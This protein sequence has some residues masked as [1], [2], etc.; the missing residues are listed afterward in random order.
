MERTKV[1]AIIPARQEGEWIAKTVHSL[2]DS[3]AELE[4]IIVV[5]DGSTDGSCAELTDIS[6]LVRVIRHDKPRGIA[7]SRNEGVAFCSAEID[8][9][10]ILD[11]HMVIPDAAV[12]MVVESAL[13]HNAVVCSSV[14]GLG[15]TNVRNAARFLFMDNKYVGYRY[16]FDG[17]EELRS[18]RLMA[19]GHEPGRVKDGESRWCYICGEQMAD[20]GQCASCSGGTY[21][22]TRVCSTEPE[23]VYLVEHITGAF[24]AIPREVWNKIGGW[25]NTAGEWGHSEP[26]ISIACFFL[27]IPMVCDTGAI[28]GH[29]YGSIGYSFDALSQWRN[30]ARAYAVMFD[31]ETI[32]NYWYPILST[33]LSPET[34]KEIGE[35]AIAQ[36]EVFQGNKVRTDREF[37]T[38]MLKAPVTEDCRIPRVAVV[39]PSC[40][41]GEEVTRTVTSL[42]DAQQIWTPH[43]VVVDDHSTDESCE[44]GRRKL[45]EVTARRPGCLIVKPPHRLGVAGARNFG[46][47][48]DP[49]AEIYVFTDAHT[50]WPLHGVR[51]LVQSALDQKALV[52][53]AFYNFK[54][55][56]EPSKADR[57][58]NYGATLKVREDM[59]GLGN[60]YNR[61]KPT[62]PVSLVQSIIGSSYAI[63]GELFKKMDGW[64]DVPGGIWGYGETEWAL[65]SYFL[66][67]PLYV[68]SRVVVGHRLRDGAQFP[69]LIGTWGVL[70]R[71]YFVHKAFFSEETYRELWKPILKNFGRRPLAVD[72][73]MFC[74]KW[75]AF[76]EEHRVKSEADFFREMLPGKYPEREVGSPEK[77]QAPPERFSPPTLGP[78]SHQD[79]GQEMIAACC[80][81]GGWKQYI[82][83]GPDGKWFEMVAA[84]EGKQIRVICQSGVIACAECGMLLADAPVRP[85]ENA[86][87]LHFEN[88]LAALKRNNWS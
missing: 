29:R 45:P 33:H 72:W 24:Y 61:T 14:Y 49:D 87:P 4:E 51:D 52:A 17:D 81:K 31:E 55:E 70:A 20:R 68:D 66:G 11:A 83:G 79:D 30:A 15:K 23:L 32:K 74:H 73:H 40:N 69:Y 64:I 16:G 47:A 8:V 35:G 86:L 10:L 37:F 39:I 59:R 53:A 27:G 44:Y 88:Q 58:I 6:P 62:A 12:N 56:K 18:A 3:D 46:A 28:V 1:A 5:D 41:E 82:R 43:I 2:I 67:L 54:G 19:M 42:L 9:Y 48:Q 75:R 80:P 60:G 84:Q 63:P 36:R 34:L 85:A 65:R 13:R 26:T 50:R 77:R 71:A 21:R 7:T 57:K 22:H 38:E 25:Y 78:T 76:M